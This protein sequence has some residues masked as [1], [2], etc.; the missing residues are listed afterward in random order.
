MT[1]ENLQEIIEDVDR[2]MERYWVRSGEQVTMRRVLTDGE[3]VV[4]R[5]LMQG[6]IAQ[7]LNDKK[8][9]ALFCLV[10]ISN[11]SIYEEPVPIMSEGYIDLRRLM[12]STKIVY[13]NTRGFV[14]T[15]KATAHD[16]YEFI[17][18]VKR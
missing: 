10:D 2:E 13:M 8:I 15:Y 4:S 16:G 6:E 7:A 11:G 5:I 12:G 3:F 9:W 17:M 1:D 18:K 14:R